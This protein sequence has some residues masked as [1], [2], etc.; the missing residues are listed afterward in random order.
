[1]LGG[2]VTKLDRGLDAFEQRNW[3]R[4]R[5]LLQ[6]GLET[7][8]QAVGLHRLGLLYWRGLGGPV[9]RKAATELFARAA[10]LSH[11]GAQTAYGI[12]LRAGVGVAKDSEAARAQFRA[13]AGAG[14]GDAM[15]Q[16]AKMSEPAERRRWLKRA[17]ELGHAQAMRQYA[18]LLMAEDDASEALA[19]LYAATAL[20]GDDNV[21]ARAFALAREMSA[22]EIN[23]AQKRGRALLRQLK[24]DDRARV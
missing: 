20:S 10:D 13:G 11:P 2:R 19:W 15:L 4:A 24:D 5:R 21:R 8:E 3:K 18:D 17:S 14:D 23:G 12:A 1:M 16:L 6:D 7:E 9:D 22:F